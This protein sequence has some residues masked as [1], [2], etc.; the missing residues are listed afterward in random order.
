MRKR[1][2]N[3]LD[4]GKNKHSFVTH[5]KSLNTKHYFWI[6]YM[7]NNSI[8]TRWIALEDKIINWGTEVIA[9]AKIV[10]LCP[11]DTS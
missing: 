7:K 10:F 11:R 3:V 1:L 2:V 5:M 6:R 8:T 9:G 4:N